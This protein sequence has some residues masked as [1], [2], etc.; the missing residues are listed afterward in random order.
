MGFQN[1]FGSAEYNIDMR[2]LTLMKENYTFQQEVAKVVSDEV[3]DEARKE[4]FAFLNSEDFKRNFDAMSK[5]LEALERSKGLSQEDGEL[6]KTIISKFNAMGDTVSSIDSLGKKVR[7]IETQ[8][9]DDIEKV[10]EDIESHKAETDQ[11]NGVLKK[12]Q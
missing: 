8:L 9:W 3:R 4:V 6:L 10:R 12:L 11:M 5:R 2:I 7:D 1:Q